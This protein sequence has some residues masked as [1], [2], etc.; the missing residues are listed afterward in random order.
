LD[1]IID[2]ERDPS[3]FLEAMEITWKIAHDCALASDH[4]EAIT[5]RNKQLQQQN[6]TLANLLKLHI[7]EQPAGQA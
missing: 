5:N 2:G 4:I 6:Q 3:A 7:Q 1:E